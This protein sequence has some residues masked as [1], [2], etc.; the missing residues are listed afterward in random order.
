MDCFFALHSNNFRAFPVLLTHE[1]LQC[2]AAVQSNE[3]STYTFTFRQSS[4]L[5]LMWYISLKLRNCVMDQT[6]LHAAAS[7]GSYPVVKLLLDARVNIDSM[8]S[9]GVSCPET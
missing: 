7:G 3:L 9:N 5:V 6:P 2:Q 4:S 8:D 1:K